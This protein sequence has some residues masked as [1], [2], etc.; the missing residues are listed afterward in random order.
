MS[1]TLNIS[2]RE[3]VETECDRYNFETPG[4]IQSHG[5][6]LV[7]QEPSFKIVQ[8]S[9]NTSQVI[10]ID[11]KE[12]INQTVTSFLEP[13]SA[14]KLLKSTKSVYKRNVK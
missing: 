6:I 5:A 3:V 14:D 12:M 9:Q 8:L 10:G 1:N 2:P 7:L 13:K 4:K 11:H